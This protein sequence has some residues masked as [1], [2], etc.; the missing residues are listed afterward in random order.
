MLWSRFDTGDDRVFYYLCLAGLVLCYLSAR[1]LRASRSGRVFVAVRDNTRAAESFGVRRETTLLAAF[2]VSGAMAALAGGLLALQQGVVDASAFPL[3][4]SLD[5]FVFTVIGGLGSLPGAVA[6]AVLYEGLR[7]F[8]PFEGFFTFAISSGVLTI[9]TVAPGGL[10]EVGHRLRDAWLRRL[11]AAHGIVVPSLLADRLLPQQADGDRAERPPFVPQPDAL[12]V[13]RGVDAGYDGVQILFGVDLEV[14]RGEVLALLG[15]NGAGKSTLLRAVSGLL[16]PTAGSITLDG[17]ELAGRK[18]QEIARLGVV[19]VPG[20]RGVFPTLTVREHF[21]VAA[22]RQDKARAAAAAEGVL[23]RFPG[24]RQRLDTMA[25]NLSGGEQQ[26]LALGLALL[27]EPSLLVIDELSLGLAP[28]VVAELLDLVRA[29]NAAGTA[30]VLVEQSVNVALT[31]ADR[32][33]FLEKGEV[34]FEGPTAELL[35]RGDIVRSV[36]LE[37]GRGAAPATRTRQRV[38]RGPALSAAGDGPA[39]LD[40]GP[41]LLEVTDLR[42]GFGGVQAVDGVSLSVGRGEVVGL[43]GPNGAGKTTVFDLVSGHLRA[44]AGRVRLDGMDVSDWPADR[45]A[46]AGLG[47]SFQDARIFGSMTVAENLAVSLERHLPVHDHLA[48]ALGL[49]EVREAE[50]DV[51]WTVADLVELMQLG[52]YRD[53]TVRELSTGS[54][55]IVDLAMAVAH[56]PS[57]LLL[58]EPSSGI[59]QREAE[60]L[61]PLLLRVRDETGCALLVIEHD[62]PLVTGIAHRLV[63]LELGRVLVEGAPSDVVRDPLVVAAYL[64]DPSSAA[65]GRSGAVTGRPGGSAAVNGRWLRAGGAVLLVMVPPLLSA[66]AGLAEAPVAAGWWSFTARGPV[67]APPPDVGKGELLVQGGAL[68]PTAVSALRFTPA[69]GWAAGRLVLPLS[70]AT[71]RAEGVLVCQAVGPWQPQEAGAWEDAPAW[72]CGRSRPARLT[73]DGG[74]LQV[75]DV[76][77]LAAADG[78]I[79]LV[80]VPG[81]ADRVVL[82]EPTAGALTVTGPAAAPTGPPDPDEQASA[83]DPGSPVGAGAPPAGGLD[84]GVLCWAAVR[85]AAAEPGGGCGAG[86]CRP[87]PR[88]RTRAGRC[89]VSGTGR[90]GVRRCWGPARRDDTT[91]RW[92]L[93]AEALLV[94]ATFGLLGWGPLAFLQRVTG[95]P[96]ARTASAVSAGSRL[97]GRVHRPRCSGLSASRHLVSAPPPQAL[98]WCKGDIHG[99]KEVFFMTT[100]ELRPPTC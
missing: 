16:R 21:R 93:A 94:L 57:V 32:A 91:T 73:P 80:L 79:S 60:A 43:I 14:R 27:A 6:G 65:V 8:N 67:A 58:D 40:T 46:R 69:A 98:S 24:L 26:Q 56:Q 45:R 37:G 82:A 44:S 78:S 33:Y 17:V 64:G 15:T 71:R 100:F 87:R 51:A 59:A 30:V 12:L 5:A 2:A 52:A 92:L 25:G 62:L 13:C 68:T 85:R 42:V 34:R 61:G 81:P 75:D 86:R 89:A 39:G 88:T 11:A 48:A 77:P 66:S 55:R 99:R 74:A 28:K 41:A 84:G 96:V 23:D 54:R 35:D 47:R 19:Q 29:I 53:K 31:V 70:G 9:L 3:Q 63:A 36:F 50:V 22:W 4:L 90:R 76:R 95:E 1:S 18:P 7:W 10:A 38:R 83:G 49:P 97:S 20:G 72:S